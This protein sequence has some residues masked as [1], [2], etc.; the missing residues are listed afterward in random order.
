MGVYVTKQDMIERFGEQELMLLT[1]RATPPAGSIVESVLDQCIRDA[2]DLI[3]GH[4]A[5]RYTLPLAIVPQ[6]LKR[7]AGTIA[8]FYLHKNGAPDNVRADF[9]DARKLLRAVATGE[10]ALGLSAGG[11]KPAGTNAAQMESGVSVFA[12]D[13]SKGFI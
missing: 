3:D 5:G 11:E 7:T 2:G 8:R 9:E 4:L 12:R 10:V 1:D 13:K 6:I